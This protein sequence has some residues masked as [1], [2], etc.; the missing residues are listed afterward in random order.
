MEREKSYRLVE[1]EIRGSPE[2]KLLKNVV[3]KP[4]KMKIPINYSLTTKK[5]FYQ[6]TI[7]LN[8]VI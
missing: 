7:S 3:E 2:P 1:I 4:W 6:V 8:I 5:F